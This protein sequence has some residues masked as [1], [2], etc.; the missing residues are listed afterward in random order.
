MADLLETQGWDALMKLMAASALALPPVLAERGVT[1]EPQLRP[2]TAP[3][4][5]RGAALSDL[6][7]PEQVATLRM[8]VLLLPWAG[9][10]G[11]PL[12]TAE[13]LHELIPASELFLAEDAADADTWPDR[14]E[15][16][17]A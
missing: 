8:P 14:V 11:H 16:F 1:P 12:S 15:A 9:D 2:A 17:L 4:V 5:L 10:A 6:P 7:S 13:R 3:A